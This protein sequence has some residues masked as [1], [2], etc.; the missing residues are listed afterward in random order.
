[1]KVKAMGYELEPYVTIYLVPETD[2]ERVLLRQI[3]KH[4]RMEL[5]NGCADRTGQG[6]AI[7]QKPGEVSDE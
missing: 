2:E 3:W 7:T 6:Y 1:M 4:G 5:S